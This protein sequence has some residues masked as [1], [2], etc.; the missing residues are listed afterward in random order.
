MSTSLSWTITSALD[1]VLNSCDEVTAT[2]L[3]A[4]VRE[5][6]DMVGSSFVTDANL[7]P[8]LT[9]SHQKLHGM[10]VDALGESYSYNVTTFTTTASTDTY[11]M[12]CRFFKL[13]GVDMW[14]GDRAYALRPFTRADRNLLRNA[15]T[16]GSGSWRGNLPLY[17]LTGNNLKLYPL[18]SPDLTCDVIYAK[19]ANL[20][21]AGSDVVSYPNGW[22]RFI[23]IDCAIQLIL[24]EESSVG[25][26]VEERAAIIREIEAS[27]E[28]RDLANPK[29][30]VDVFASEY[31]DY[32]W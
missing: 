8:L 29:R 1:G 20:L 7:Y 28:Q 15:G 25:G 2:T 22:E 16:S 26:L 5:R 3:I 19:G 31:G 17:S 32:E 11:E 24:K 6:A 27:K 30:T 4:R 18:P 12:P 9:E 23:V 13:Y 21:T 10:L 14:I